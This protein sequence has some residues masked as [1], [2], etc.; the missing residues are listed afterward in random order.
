MS[1][2]DRLAR[3]NL[4]IPAAFLLQESEPE[5][6]EPEEP[7]P[8]PIKIH[9]DTFI[10]RKY[11]LDEIN[12]KYI[13]STRHI[14]PSS[15]SYTLDDFKGN[16]SF[17]IKYGG[18]KHYWW[19]FCKEK[20][21]VKKLSRFMTQKKTH[22][23]NT[24]DVD[25]R[26]YN[27]TPYNS[28]DDNIKDI[29]QKNSDLIVD[30]SKI[31]DVYM[32][33]HVLPLLQRLTRF[34]VEAADVENNNQYTEVPKSEDKYSIKDFE[35]GN[36]YLIK[37][38]NDPYQLCLLSYERLYYVQIEDDN[39]RSDNIKLSYTPAK[40]STIKSVYLVSSNESV[41]I[42]GGRHRRNRSRKLRCKK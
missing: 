22:F 34:E 26:D 37:R 19:F 1:I 8:E 27:F 36:R 14:N 12:E 35:D 40:F 4:T 21:G 6:E 9:F 31:K 11:T 16:T 3:L 17:L 39:I 7:D 20:A 18:N 33:L 28:F 2:I 10:L 32:I 25:F 30:F 13:H 15:G 23:Q 41:V 38:G 24:I 42:R 29:I 5:E